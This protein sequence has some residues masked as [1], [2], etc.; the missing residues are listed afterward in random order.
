MAYTA[1]NKSSL[2][3]NPILY[4]GNGGTNAI[5]GVGFQPDVTWIKDRDASTNQMF[6]DAV[7]GVTKELVV[8][9]DSAGATAANSLTAWGADGFTVGD[10]GNVN[11][12]T[13]NIASWNWKANGAGSANTVGDIESTV[14]VNTTS[15]FSIVKYIG[16]GTGSDTVGHGLGVAPKVVIIKC[17]S[18]ASTSW[19]T[20]ILPV[21]GY[22]YLDLDNAITLNSTW[23]PLTSTTFELENTWGAYNTAGRT[24]MAYCFAEISG[25]SKF[26]S[27]VGNGNVNG[28]FVYTGFRPE[29]LIIKETSTSATWFLIDS[30]R[31]P[32][33]VASI[34]TCPDLPNADT[35]ASW[36]NTDF[37]SNGFKFRTTEVD[38][39]YDGSTYVYMAFGQT[40]VGTNNIAANAR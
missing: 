15:G 7:R 8:S 36:V 24:Y 12:N 18:D 6:F 37:L 29:C 16:S 4:T 10:S 1:I 5:T 34:K 21:E 19:I 14:S 9:N 32:Y 31:S 39:N 38:I 28:T 25:F 27:Y 35:D 23:L 33:N 11:T 3:M 20:Q 13:N 2:F 17:T 40:L 26:G 22:L 30:K